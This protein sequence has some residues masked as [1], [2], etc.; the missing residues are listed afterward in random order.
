MKL[1]H[2]DHISKKYNHFIFEINKCVFFLNENL[3]YYHS[4]LKGIND[5]C[6]VYDLYRLVA[7]I[8]L[9]S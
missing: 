2:N 3:E 7:D 1:L 4:G 5:I 8:L 6:D 9:I